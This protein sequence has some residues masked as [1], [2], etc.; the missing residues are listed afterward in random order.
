MN[1]FLT[2]VKLTRSEF[3]NMRFADFCNLWQISDELK[4]L[5]ATSVAL[6]QLEQQGL[7]N[8]LRVIKKIHE[9]QTPFQ[10]TSPVSSSRQLQF[11]SLF[12]LSNQALE[13]F[14][15]GF[16][17]VCD[18]VILW[19]QITQTISNTQTS[20]ALDWIQKLY[21]Y[22]TQKNLVN[23]IEMLRHPLLE[24]VDADFHK[25]V[26]NWE[27][28]LRK[29]QQQ[30]LD[31]DWPNH[32]L[33][34]HL[35]SIACEK[36][37]SS[38]FKEIFQKLPLTIQQQ[39]LPLTNYV[40][41]LNNTIHCLEWFKGA[42]NLGTY[43]PKIGLGLHAA[44]KFKPEQIV[45]CLKHNQIRPLQSH[46]L[47]KNVNVGNLPDL[48]FQWA[49][50]KQLN[51]LSYCS[52]ATFE[53][54]LVQADMLEKHQV[55]R[56]SMVGERP[57]ANPIVSSRP[58][59]ISATGFNQLMQDPYGFYARYIL[60]LRQLERSCAQNF[61]K[62]FGLATHKIIE[63]YLKQ[64]LES[65]SQYLHTLNLNSHP[66]LWKG[67]LLR[68]LDWVHAQMNDLHPIKFQSEQDLS[69]ELTPIGSIKLKA[70]ID[71]CIFT[72]Q[73]NL[74]VNFKTGMP[75]S[76][77]EVTAGYSPQLAIEMFLTSKTHPN[78]STQAEFWQLKGTQPAGIVSSSIAIPIDTLQ[79]ELEKITL[80][81][82]TQ[83]TSF[84]TCP[85]PSKTPK[86]NEY[87]NLERLA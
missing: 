3:P 25:I 10:H 26:L 84:L 55:Q 20:T 67:K 36:N 4:T 14:N 80:H 29:N 79:A 18:D 1:D 12:S 58:T 65:A 40:T 53:H 21:T 50:K 2:C 39:L 9:I 22:A 57:I 38:I 41:L 16:V 60:K 45:F 48:L 69:A 52:D 73:G 6:T 78:T 74:V 31:T 15:Q 49:A 87:K 43:A 54:P 86:Y 35:L 85:W 62:E 13:F 70:R 5:N 42:V 76:K 17:L 19:E 28:T 61:A 30:T 81:Y 56:V 27:C 72:Y 7:H 68:I 82:L 66:I 37:F 51:V 47:F 11:S 32:S 24:K 63:V 64:G 83:N 44:L 59:T 77:T 8:L 23:A 46:P 71:A 33:C 75:P 34:Q